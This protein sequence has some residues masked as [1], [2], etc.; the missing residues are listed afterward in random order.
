MEKEQ[1]EVIFSSSVGAR[2]E[3]VLKRA[4]RKVDLHIMPV[5]VLLYLAS[6]IDRHAACSIAPPDG[7]LTGILGRISEMRGFWAWRTTSD[8]L[9]IS[10][11]GLGLSAVG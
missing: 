7:E 8:C 3:E 6:Y 9:R 10:I 1:N 2:D 11:I 5:A 4:W